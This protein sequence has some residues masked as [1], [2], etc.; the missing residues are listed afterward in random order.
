MSLESALRTVARKAIHATGSLVTLRQVTPGTYNT[1]TRAVTSELADDQD[2]PGRFE[3]YIDRDIQ[4]TVHAGDR[5]LFVAAADLTW[6]PVERDRVLLDDAVLDI[7]T[8]KREM[9]NALPAFYVLQ[10]RG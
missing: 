3:E 2:V 6:I 9:A 5:K 1:T 4:G 7:V 10:V 8:V